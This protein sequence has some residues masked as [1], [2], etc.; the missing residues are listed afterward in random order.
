MFLP[1]PHNLYFCSINVEQNAPLP[2]WQR[3]FPSM[4]L[5]FQC[6]AFKIR[7]LATPWLQ[8]FV[9]VHI[10]S[11]PYA[12]PSHICFTW[13]LGLVI[14]HP[15]LAFLLP[16]DIFHHYAWNEN[17]MTT[18]KSTNHSCSIFLWFGRRWVMSEALEPAKAGGALCGAFKDKELQRQLAPFV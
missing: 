10:F 14:D 12:N 5:I 13:P 8:I 7:H 17:E 9:C 18:N 6:H 16:R 15:L 4:N 11:P 3:V 1:S 2:V